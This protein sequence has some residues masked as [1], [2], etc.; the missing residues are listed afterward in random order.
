MGSGG[1]SFKDQG[2]GFPSPDGSGTR[3]QGLNSPWN[4]QTGNSRSLSLLFGCWNGCG[5]GNPGR[6][7]GRGGFLLEL[8]HHN[9]RRPTS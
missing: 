6:E 3:S 9:I 4:W 7:L 1:Y 5:D 8:K 2:G